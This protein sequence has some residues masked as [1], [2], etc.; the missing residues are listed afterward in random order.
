LNIE[1]PSKRATFGVMDAIWGDIE[2]TTAEY[3]AL[4]QT[5][6]VLDIQKFNM[7]SITHH[8]TR[9]EGSTLSE[10]ETSL[11][12]EE[13]ITAKGKPLDQQLMVEDHYH[14]LKFTLSLAEQ[15][16][17]LSPDLLTSIAAAVMKRTGTAVNAAAGSWDAAK[18]EF[19]KA[20]VRSQ[21]QYYAA[22][23]KVPELVRQLCLHLQSKIKTVHSTQEILELAFSAH[24]N[25]VQI[26][27]W[28]D[29]NGRTSRLLMNF[30]EH[31]HNQPLTVVRSEGKQEYI[32]AILA[33]KEN[34]DLSYINAFLANEHLH[35]LKEEIN[36]FKSQFSNPSKKQGNDVNKDKG[37]T[38]LF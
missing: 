31:Y 19:R 28:S 4:L 20:A 25:L 14:A 1:K 2:R 16:Q 34:E 8:S 30:I 32:D 33:S 5:G 23:D 11:L 15:K 36:L 18:G 24:Y 17:P 3:K 7:I 22:Y 10:T 35:H 21:K 9:I 27:P 13:G 29:G 26:H 37:F 38:L 6:Q 12:L